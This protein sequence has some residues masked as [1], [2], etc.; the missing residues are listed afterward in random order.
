MESASFKE[1]QVILILFRILAGF[2]SLSDCFM[3][4]L[5][6]SKDAGC[7]ITYQLNIWT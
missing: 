3:P 5:I 4:S 2:S 7:Q 6:T 1:I